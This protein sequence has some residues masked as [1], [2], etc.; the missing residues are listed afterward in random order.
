MGL[1]APVQTD[2]GP[3]SCAGSYAGNVSVPVDP[4]DPAVDD[5][6]VDTLRSARRCLLRAAGQGTGP[7]PNLSYL[8]G[9]L[10]AALEQLLNASAL[11]SAA[12]REEDGRLL[13]TA[14][15]EVRALRSLCKS[16]ESGIPKTVAAACFE[17]AHRVAEFGGDFRV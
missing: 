17:L 3:R 13:E 4:L 1:V 5:A 7:R 2:E 16:S 11:A 14:A 6:R 15:D 12:G 9:W 8:D 10:S